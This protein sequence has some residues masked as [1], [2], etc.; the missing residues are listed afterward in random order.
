MLILTGPQSALLGRAAFLSL[1]VVLGASSVEVGARVQSTPPV[2]I[3]PPSS[4]ENPAPTPVPSR[5]VPPVRVDVPSPS[6]PVSSTLLPPPGLPASQSL[7]GADIAAPDAQ[8][9]GPVS[10][11]MAVDPATDPV[12]SFVEVTAPENEF[13]GVVQRAVERHPGREENSGYA[14][15]ARYA[16]EQQRAAMLPAGE[17]DITGFQV[18]ARDF[19]SDS[20]DNIVERTR[21]NRRFDQLATVNQ[22]LFDF[23]ATANRTHAAF[24]RLRAAA[25]GVDNAAEQVALNTIAAWYDVYALRTTLVLSSAYRTDQSQSRV[26][27]GKRIAQGAS[28]EVDAALIDNTIA[29][30]NL[31]IARFDQQLATAVARFRELTGSEPPDGLLRAPELGRIPATIEIARAAAENTSASNAARY[32]ARA[33]RRDATAA[34]RDLYPSVGASLDAGRY[35]LL[36]TRRDYDVVARITLRQRF[37]GGLPERA[38]AANAHAAALDARARRIAEENGRDAAIAFS[39]LESLDAQVEALREAYIATRQTRD[40]TM[41]RFR[42]SR[43]TLFDTINASDTFFAAAAGYIQAVARRDA[44]RY[45]L[46]ARTGGLLDALEVP[47]YTLPN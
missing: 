39:E 26:A 32:Q 25:L 11:P 36:R 27:I 31:Q 14:L 17:I 47:A 30:L 16:F 12:L 9:P 41:E 43:G 6:L 45:E 38:A 20:I 8:L 22:L 44:V 28:A 33:A 37:A 2:E 21:A 15:E 7:P 18:L 1:C 29:Q 13:R 3:R 5:D 35:G 10:R 4:G 46:L 42:F 24:E 40:A 34:E 19:P 23:G